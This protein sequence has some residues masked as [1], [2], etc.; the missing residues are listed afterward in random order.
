[1]VEENQALNH[2]LVGRPRHRAQQNSSSRRAGVSCTASRALYPGASNTELCPTTTFDE[3]PV[4]RA[5]QEPD[6]AE[7][8]TRRN[9]VWRPYH[10]RLQA[11]LD[12]IKARQQ[13]AAVG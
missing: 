6:E 9:Q 13:F 11:E 7:I 5:G 1:M 10:E 2:T 3:L 12:A 8:E 4:Y